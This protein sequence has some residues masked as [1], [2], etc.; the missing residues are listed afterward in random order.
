VVPTF[1]LLKVRVGGDTPATG[2]PTARPV[3]VRLTVWLEA[4]LLLLSLTISVPVRLP[5]AVGAKV[6]LMVQLPPSR[7]AG[8]AVIG[9]A[10]IGRVRAADTRYWRGSARPCRYYSGSPACAELV[11]PTFW[12]LKV[13]LG[14]DT[15][16]AGTPTPVPFR[17]TDCV[18]PE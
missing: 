3:P 6:T 4:V 16:A 15:P 12:L 17:V 2:A 14:G 13:R 10:E 9:L 18:V 8:S 5:A 11:V 7:H 1:W